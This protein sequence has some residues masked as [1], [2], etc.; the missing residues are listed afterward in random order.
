MADLSA[1]H[2]IIYEG[3]LFARKW[4]NGVLSAESIGPFEVTG[5]SIT[6]TNDPKYRYSNITGQSGK[7]RGG[8]ARTKPTEFELKANALN[9]DIAALFLLA[10][11]S[12]V[13]VTSGSVTGESVTFTKLDTWYKL[14]NRNVTSPAITGKTLGTDFEVDLAAGLIRAL[15]TGTITAAS[16]QSVNYSK[17]GIS[18]SRA[19]IGALSK[20]DI[21][22][23]GELVNSETGSRAYVRAPQATVAP[24]GAIN[25]I[26]NDYQEMTLK[27]TC[28]QRT[29]ETADLYLDDPVTFS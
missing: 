22:L 9:A 6:T 23:F 8:F 27:G 4:V 5:F 17:G 29:G 3:K 24:T 2:G 15:S 10:S 28:I 11:A 7:A 26:G 12:T 25:L 16:T 18:S 13:T 21:E 19:S 14:A 1:Q 20:S